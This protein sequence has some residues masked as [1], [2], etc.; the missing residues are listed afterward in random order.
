MASVFV[1]GVLSAAQSDQRPHTGVFPASVRG[2]LGDPRFD[3]ERTGEGSGDI[4]EGGGLSAITTTGRR[5]DE[6]STDKKPKMSSRSLARVHE[7]RLGH[8]LQSS[9]EKSMWIIL[10]PRA[11]LVSDQRMLWRSR[12]QLTVLLSQSMRKFAPS[13]SLLRLEPARCCP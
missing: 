13:Q 12:G 3:G 7:D 6:Q 2:N 5:A 4:G 8:A 1:D 10:R 9:G 11:V